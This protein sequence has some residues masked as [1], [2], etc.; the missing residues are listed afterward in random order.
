MTDGAGGTKKGR[1][2]PHFTRMSGR[3]V[4]EMIRAQF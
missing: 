3:T 4:K 2:P 1:P